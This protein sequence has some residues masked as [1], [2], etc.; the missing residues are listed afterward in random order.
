MRRAWWSRRVVWWWCGVCGVGVGMGWGAWRKEGPVC[1][2]GWVGGWVG[3]HH[4]CCLPA[5][6]SRRHAPRPPTAA[7]RHHAPPPPQAVLAAPWDLTANF[8]G[9][10]GGKAQLQVGRTR[11]RTRLPRAAGSAGLAACAGHGPA[12]AHPL[13]A[14]SPR[15]PLPQITGAGD[16]TGRGV[17]FSLIRDVR[18]KVRKGGACAR[19]ACLPAGLPAPPAPAR[20][21]ARPLLLRPYIENG[22]AG[23]TNRVR[24]PR[25]RR[26]STQ[27]TR[28]RCC[29]S[30]GRARCRAPTRI[31]GA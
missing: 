19:R 18:H 23:G 26:T 14:P 7:H 15:G 4:F 31:C 20:P 17:G 13:P 3:G 22:G 11:G 30:S 24:L 21:A 28:P 10:A 8:L 1:G 25:A 27:T 2:R 9:W 5:A 12:R 29:T 16:P 6:R